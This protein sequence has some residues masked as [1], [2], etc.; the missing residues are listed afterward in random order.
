MGFESH[1]TIAGAPAAVHILDE[2]QLGMC[3]YF[4]GRSLLYLHANLRM[5]GFG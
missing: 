2:Q 4:H 3:R 1:A 5:L